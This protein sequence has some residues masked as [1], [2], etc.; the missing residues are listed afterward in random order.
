MILNDS[1]F[2]TLS[3]LRHFVR[4]GSAISPSFIIEDL[5]EDSKSLKLL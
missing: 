5:N 3:K 2:M 1:A 4:A